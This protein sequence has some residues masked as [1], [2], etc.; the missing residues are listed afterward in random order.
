MSEEKNL[1]RC[2]GILANL[3]KQLHDPHVTP[4]CRKKKR[5]PSILVAAPHR[6]HNNMRQ[7]R[8]TSFDFELYQTSSVALGL[9]PAVK[10]NST[11]GKRPLTDAA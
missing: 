11:T 2:V 6:P 3:Q 7:T 10:S 8:A 1:V 9:A 5:S 4:F